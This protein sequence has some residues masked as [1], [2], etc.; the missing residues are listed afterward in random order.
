MDNILEASMAC[1]L[2]L[3][4]L[5]PYVTSGGVRVVYHPHWGEY[6]PPTGE[7]LLPLGLSGMTKPFSPLFISGMY[8]VRSASTALVRIDRDRVID[9]FFMAGLGAV[10]E[11]AL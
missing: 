9:D 7:S 2:V 3:L 10:V 8:L 4:L 11:V 5:A 1:R 6:S